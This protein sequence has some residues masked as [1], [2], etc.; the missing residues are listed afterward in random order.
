M[1]ALIVSGWAITSEG[2]LAK[3]KSRF[4]LTGE[5]QPMWG[6]GKGIGGVELRRGQGALGCFQSEAVVE[7][8]SEGANRPRPS[9]IGVRL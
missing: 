8:P 9:A 3:G 4:L 7:A 2:S 1:R 6:A 5:P